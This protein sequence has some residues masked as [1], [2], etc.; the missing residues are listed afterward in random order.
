MC[1]EVINTDIKKSG[2]IWVQPH[3]SHVVTR[4]FFVFDDAQSQT[5]ARAVHT[6]NN[7]SVLT[8]IENPLQFYGLLDSGVKK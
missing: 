7:K 1:S 5:K 6:Q 3:E 8:E 2:D 4:F